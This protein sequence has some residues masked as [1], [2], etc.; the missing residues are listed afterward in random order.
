MSAAARWRVQTVRVAGIH[1]HAGMKLTGGAWRRCLLCW[2]LVVLACVAWPAAARAETQVGLTAEAVVSA[3]GAPTSSQVA[4]PYHWDRHQPG[5]AGVASFTLSFDFSAPPQGQYGLYMHRVGNAYEIWVNGWLLDHHGSL[6]D[7]NGSDSGQVP[8]YIALPPGLLRS[9]NQVVVQ[10]RAD[11]G[12]RAGLAPLHIGPAAEVAPLYHRAHGWRYT[13]SVVVV[14]V[15]L[16]VG[17]VALVLWATQH[18]IGDGTGPARRDAIYLWAA[19]AELTWTLR[20]GDVL[21]D[22]PPWPWPWWGL[23]PVLALAVWAVAMGAFC[24]QV[25]GWS[26]HPLA[27][28]FVRWLWVMA[29]LSLPAATSALVYGHPQALTLWYG[30]LGAGFACMGGFFVYRALL[31]KAR[32]P[33]RLVAVAVLVNVL[34]GLRDFYVFRINPVHGENT[35]MRYSSLLFGVVLAVIVLYRFK[36]ANDRARGLMGELSARVAARE[37]ELLASYRRLADL[38]R[39]QATVAERSRI[40]RDMHDGVGSHIT[41]AVRQ[42]QSGRADPAE[43][44]H[45]LQDALDQLKLSIDAMHL[46]PGDVGALLANL[47]YRLEPRFAAMDVALSW[48]VEPLPELGRLQAADMRQLQYMLFE[49]LSNVLQ[50]A[51]AHRL[52]VQAQPQGDG[53]VVRIVD[54]GCGFDVAAVRSK[55]IAAMRE[56]A[57][58][59]GAVL[60]LRSQPGHTVVEILLA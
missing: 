18:E 48:E 13:G 56:R 29:V 1:Y 8:R 52:W 27:R 3:G 33:H 32:F 16:L 53:V 60:N 49:A 15:S 19:V 31:P 55:G 6:A 57:Q 47:R 28:G 51:H 39:E 9:S 45:T 54:D 23:V 37:Q 59:M 11:V 58:A 36:Q 24:F 21:I 34:V 25:A 4:L 17:L 43:L 46:V 44:A 40:L 26:P 30:G 22:S 10:I 7:F 41:S 35:Y 14:C 38:A 5:Q 50:H 2:W 42:L 12:R 20:V